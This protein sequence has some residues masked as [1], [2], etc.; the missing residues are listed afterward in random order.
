MSS[1]CLQ[2]FCHHYHSS[3]DGVCM[4]KGCNCSPELYIAEGDPSFKNFAYHQSILS[5]MSDLHQKVTW[6][7]ESVSGMR[8]T[9]DWEFIQACWYYFI[10]FSYG[11]TWSQEWFKKIEIECPP[12]TI[13]RIRRKVCH[14]ELEQLRIFNDEVKAMVKRDEEGTKA[15]WELTEKIK[16]FWA[17]SKYIPTDINMLKKKQIKESAVF[18]Y[19]ISEIEN[20]YALAQNN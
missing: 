16:K 18:E 6:M 17:D 19:S 11:E 5:K 4:S 15:Y 12:D 14:A 9:S 2:P 3:Y 20:I 10:G 13:T 8:N 1:K 7:L